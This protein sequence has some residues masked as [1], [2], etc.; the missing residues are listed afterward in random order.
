[1]PLQGLARRYDVEAL[2]AFLAAP[3]PPM[4]AFPLDDTQRRDLA[5]FL[6]AEHGS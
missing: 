3:T 1:V 4:P 6:L 5:T 2:R